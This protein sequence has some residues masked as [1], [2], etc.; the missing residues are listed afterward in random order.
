MFLKPVCLVVS[1]LRIRRD[2]LRVDV[3]LIPPLEPDVLPRVWFEQL[4]ASFYFADLSGCLLRLGVQSGVGEE[5]FKNRARVKGGSPLGPTITELVNRCVDG[6]K[7]EVGKGRNPGI[8]HTEIAVPPEYSIPVLGRLMKFAS[9][10]D[11]KRVEDLG[12]DST[13]FGRIMKRLSWIPGGPYFRSVKIL[14]GLT[15]RTPSEIMNNRVLTALYS[16]PKMSYGEGATPGEVLAETQAP[17]IYSLDAVLGRAKSPD[18]VRT[19]WESYPF[20]TYG[21]RVSV[22]MSIW[23][24]LSPESRIPE[25]DLEASLRSYHRLN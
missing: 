18:E 6:W 8:M 20:T 19:Y 12:L 11:G 25:E 21:G 5:T 1:M 16:R 24:D 10:A 9:Y 23:R 4:C 15:G 7:D 3:G 13:S 14:A 17:T 2:H 22:V